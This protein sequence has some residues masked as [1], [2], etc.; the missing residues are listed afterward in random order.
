MKA[1][2]VVMVRESE[3]REM[4][5]ALEWYA[6][7]GEENAHYIVD[8]NGGRLARFS[9]FASRARAALAK[10]EAAATQPV[11]Y[12]YVVAGE[13]EQIEWGTDVDLPDDPALVWLYPHPTPDGC[14]REEK[15]QWLVIGRDRSGR[16]RDQCIRCGEICVAE[17]GDDG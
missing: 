5:A 12:A 15:H 9:E 4:R 6:S 14:G 7:E 3:W 17:G 10:S 2:K 8:A 1:E 16:H 13:C 11:A